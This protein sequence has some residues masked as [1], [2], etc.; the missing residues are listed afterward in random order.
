MEGQLEL[1]RRRVLADL[2]DHFAAGHLRPPTLEQRIGEALAAT[3]PSELFDATWDLPRTMWQRLTGLSRREI[4]SRECARLYVDDAV[5]ALLDLREA[6]RTWL[7]GRSR[8]SDV[9]VE[10]PYVS[11]R[12]ALVSVRGGRC[13]VR[14]LA[15]RH[16]VWLNGRR[17]RTATLEPGDELV[18][19]LTL[20]AAVR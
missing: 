2:G 5:P 18:F 8:V 4:W 19:G 16:G 14:D 9:A 20:T 13:R 12:H 10:D 17:I 15:S 11:R 7:I 1:M 3:N 6:P